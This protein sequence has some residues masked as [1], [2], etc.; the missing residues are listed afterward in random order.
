MRWEELSKEMQDYISDELLKVTEALQNVE[1]ILKDELELNLPRE[2]VEIPEEIR[3]RLPK[4]Y[5]RT[6]ESIEDEYYLKQLIEDNTLR[7]N[8][9]YAIQYTDFLNYIFNRFSLGIDG[10]TVGKEFRKISIIYIMAIVE[11]L[12]AGIIEK[13]IT[14]CFKCQI[15]GNCTSKL[16]QCMKSHERNFRKVY[17]K[18]KYLS[19]SESIEFI[20][21]T[22][23][24]KQE[25]VEKLEHF[26]K[27]YRNR[28][29][30]QYVD[31]STGERPWDYSEKYDVALYNEAVKLLQSTK[32][33]IWELDDKIQYEC[34]IKLFESL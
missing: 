30:I 2:N 34:T 15:Y 8:I 28:I 12:L 5:I 9:A 3:I 16:A 19:F 17:E 21:E 14:T 31:R 18:N 13:F 20:K 1:D 25:Y 22:Y 6:V 26:K 27:Y 32:E 23:V 33:I 10:L 11:A 29:H 7:K 24:S 4:G